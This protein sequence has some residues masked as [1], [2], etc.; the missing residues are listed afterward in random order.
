MVAP[1]IEINYNLFNN[2][3]SKIKEQMIKF[4]YSFLKFKDLVVQFVSI[5]IKIEN[6]IKYNNRYFIIKNILHKCVA[7]RTTQKIQTLS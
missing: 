1:F 6:F 2:Y 4:I 3:K 5:N 7:L